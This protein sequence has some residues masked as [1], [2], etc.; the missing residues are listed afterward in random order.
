MCGVKRIVL[1]GLIIV[2]ALAVF[3]V[4]RQAPADTLEISVKETV[5]GIIIENTGDVDCIVFVTWTDHQEQF[6]VAVGENRVIANTPKPGN[7][8]AVSK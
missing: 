1:V 3:F 7:I 5:D 2:V 4:L 6:D 8:S